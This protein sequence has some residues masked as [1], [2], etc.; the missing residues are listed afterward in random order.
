MNPDEFGAKFESLL[1]FDEDGNA[2]HRLREYLKDDEFV[3][4]LL[5]GSWGDDQTALA[6][7]M[8]FSSLAD[9]IMAHT[10]EQLRAEAADWLLEVQEEPFRLLLIDRA[11]HDQAEL[12]RAGAAEAIA[13]HAPRTQLSASARRLLDDEEVL[14]RSLAVNAAMRQGL[15]AVVREIL[16]TETENRVVVTIHSALAENGDNVS[17]DELYVLL[18]DED[19]IVR[20]TALNGLANVADNRDT[21]RFRDAILN[22]ATRD[23]ARAV[24]VR[25]RE[26]CSELGLTVGPSP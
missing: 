23:P 4:H 17:I 6:R 20:Y 3:E 13:G 25:A 10:N 5:N 8:H 9:V 15:E 2:R 1:Q 11:A 24:S 16:G 7:A 19:Y 18:Q 14:V 22:L 26:I 12:V 21:H